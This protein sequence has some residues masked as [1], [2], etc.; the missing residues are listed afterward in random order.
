MVHVR[1]V[2]DDGFEPGKAASAVWYPKATT[3]V[4]YFKNSWCTSIAKTQFILRNAV[5]KAIL[6]AVGKSR[7]PSLF[8]DENVEEESP[9]THILEAIPPELYVTN[10]KKWLSLRA[11]GGGGGG[12][13][14]PF[15]CWSSSLVR[16]TGSLAKPGYRPRL[17]KAMLG[18][19]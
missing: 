5:W 18:R 7:T 10:H 1:I 2:R 15:C 17:G 12:M 8:L 11:G 4:Q 16:C 13:S 19:G 6:F 9:V 3:Y 14:L